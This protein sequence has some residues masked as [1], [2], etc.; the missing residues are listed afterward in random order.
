MSTWTDEL[1]AATRIA[2]ECVHAFKVL[3]R[4]AATVEEVQAAQRLLA[5]T[6]RALNERQDELTIAAKWIAEKALPNGHR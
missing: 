2:N 6:L 3:D 4:R 1:Q 5:D